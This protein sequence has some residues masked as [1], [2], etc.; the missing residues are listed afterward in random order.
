MPHARAARSAV[1]SAQ[2]VREDNLGAPSSSSARPVPQAELE[3]GDPRFSSHA[4]YF[5]FGTR[6]YMR[7]STRNAVSTIRP[8]ASSVP[9]PATPI[10]YPPRAF[11][12]GRPT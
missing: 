9:A 12:P 10:S 1:A 2:V 8:P 6:S 5:F 3:L 4:R 11:S 7:F